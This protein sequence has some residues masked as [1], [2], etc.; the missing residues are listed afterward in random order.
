MGEGGVKN[1][2][3]LPTLFMDGPLGKQG[4]LNT[5]WRSQEAVKL[6]P[7]DLFQLEITF[8]C[9]FNY[10]WGSKNLLFLIFC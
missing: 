6:E 2:K 8:L 5:R 4:C 7:W 3:K 10:D 1:P 9:V